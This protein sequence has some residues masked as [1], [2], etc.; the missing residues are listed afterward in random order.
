MVDAQIANYPFTTIT[1]N[2]GVTYIR[3]PCPHVE[4]GLPKCDPKNSRCEGGVRLV[5]VNIIDVPGLVPDAHK[6]KGL[7]N[8]FLDSLQKA[9][10]L[11]QVVDASG[12]TDLHGNACD[13]SAPWEEVEFLRR[14]IA[15]WLAGIMARHEKKAAAGIKEIAASLSGLRIDE[16]MLRASALAC[17]LDITDGLPD[18]EGT[19]RIAYEIVKRRMPI[20]VA[21]N[22]IDILQAEENFKIAKEKLGEGVFACSAAIELALRKAAEK[23]IIKYVPGEAKFEILKTP[24]AKQQEGLEKIRAFLEKNHGSG[25][26]QI[27]DWVVYSKLKGI[28]VYPVEDEHRFS[29]HKGEVLPDALLVQHGTTAIQLAEKVHSDLAKKFIGAIDVKRKMRVGASHVLGNGDVIKILA[30]R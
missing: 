11:I 24:D 10:A 22:K 8:R 7:G 15:F 18:E 9:D 4:L 13:F 27:I 14:E 28:V 23:G 21:F 6:G 29:N 3:A 26:Q 16:Q 25:V 1:P 30:S 12:K 5:P 2:V 19:V 17:G 20:A